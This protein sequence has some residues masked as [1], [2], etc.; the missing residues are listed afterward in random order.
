MFHI[1][2]PTSSRQVREFLDATGFCRLWI[3]GFA[4]LE[5]P[6]YPLTRDKQPFVWGDKEQQAFDAIK[7]A[8]MLAPALGPPDVTK[9][10]HL[11]VAKNKGIAK[12][13]VTQRLGPWKRPAAAGWPSCLRIVAA[14]M[15]LVKDTDKLGQNLVFLVPRALESVV[16]QPPD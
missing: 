16:H 15:L 6:L 10:F 5:A 4:E 2:S 11:F 1:P 7:T 13:V 3:P 8:L 9:P 12:G 14:V